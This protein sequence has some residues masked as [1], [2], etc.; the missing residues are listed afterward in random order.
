MYAAYSENTAEPMTF[1]ANH[2]KLSPNTLAAGM[3][4]NQEQKC[5]FEAGPRYGTPIIRKQ[6][7]DTLPLFYRAVAE[8]CIE[9]GRLIL[10]E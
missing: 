8:V 5:I 10:R 2:T 1:P 7:F 6:I 4:R 9:H 3:N